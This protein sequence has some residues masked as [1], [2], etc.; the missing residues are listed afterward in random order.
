MNVFLSKGLKSSDIYRENSA[1]LTT[2]PTNLDFFLISLVYFFLIYLC[3]HER[4][5]K[6]GRDIGRGKGSY[7]EPDAGLDARTLGSHP[8]P[9]ADAQPL[10]HPGVPRTYSL[11]PRYQKMRIFQIFSYSY[12][13]S[14]LPSFLANSS[15]KRHINFFFQR[16]VIKCF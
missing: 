4:Y 3:I 16:M 6:R 14:T 1:F 15:I 2:F 10:S 12:S 5:R 9:K 7:R 13:Q 8:E 11:N